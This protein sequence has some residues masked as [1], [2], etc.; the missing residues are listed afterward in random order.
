MR[1]KFQPKGLTFYICF[2]RYSGFK[3]TFG[4]ILLGWVSVAITLNDLEVS[5]QEMIKEI[6]ELRHNKW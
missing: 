5:V 3:I 4:K 6:R 1:N 2:G